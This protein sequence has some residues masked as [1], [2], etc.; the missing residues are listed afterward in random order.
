MRKERI[1]LGEIAQRALLLDEPFSAIDEG[2]RRL[3]WFEIK[4]AI[5]RVGVTA[6]HITHHLEEA[7]T[8]GDQLSVLIGGRLVQSGP[9]EEVF[10]HPATESVARFLGYRNIFQGETRPLARGTEIDLGYFSIKTG[11]KI[12]AGQPVA[13]CI[14]PQYIKI[15]RGGEP[16]RESLERNIFQGEVVSLFML[17]EYCLMRFKLAGSPR[18][19]DLESRFPAYIKERLDLSVGKK[20]SIALWEPSIVVFS[21]PSF[22]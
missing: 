20:I 14:L 22:Q 15:I 8:L 7:Y 10:R 4:Q 21:K 1:S 5:G 2:S 19:F 13:V 11:E 3:L 6:I 16:V 12:P 9:K 18:P 17:P